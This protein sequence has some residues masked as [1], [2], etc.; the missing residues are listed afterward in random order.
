MIHN[1]FKRR[2]VFDGSEHP[3][4]EMNEVESLI[5]EINNRLDKKNVSKI[6]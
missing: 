4:I 1:I 5:Y 3:T 2:W 6:N